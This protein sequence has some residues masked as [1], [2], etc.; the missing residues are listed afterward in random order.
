MKR[1]RIGI[2]YLAVRHSSSGRRPHNKSEGEFSPVAVDFRIRRVVCRNRRAEMIATKLG[3][4]REKAQFDE[5]LENR[6]CSPRCLLVST[7]GKAIHACPASLGRF[8]EPGAVEERAIAFL[9]A[10]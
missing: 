1:R 2:G 9:I 10:D 8:E 3:H 5:C 4:G 6:W 7:R